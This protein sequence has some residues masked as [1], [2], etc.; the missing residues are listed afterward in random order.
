M[1]GTCKC[2][3]SAG[4]Y[5][6]GTTCQLTCNAN[7]YRDPPTSKCV[8]LG[9]CTAPYRFG[10]AQGNCVQ[11]CTWIDTSTNTKYYAQYSTLKCVTDCGQFN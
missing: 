6:Q 8:A 1:N 3:I 10:D 9:A 7:Y 11:H 5:E 2:N 4:Y